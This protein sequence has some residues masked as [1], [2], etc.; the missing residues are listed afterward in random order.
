M[1]AKDELFHG[2]YTKYVQLMRIIA[3]KREIPEADIEDLVQETFVAYYSH[4]PLDWSE[5]QIKAALVKIMRNRCIDY[6]RKQEKWMLTYCDPASI[7]EKML[8]DE[9]QIGR[10]SLSMFL[11]RQELKEVLN[12]LRYMKEDWAEVFLLYIIE[13]RSMEEVS[14]IMGLSADACRARLSRGRKYLRRYLC[15]EEPEKYRPSVRRKTS[16]EGA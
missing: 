9:K 7:Q 12:A 8:F 14:E 10:D 5:C 1:N 15:P 4:Y 11:E 16:P 6:F 2:I 3:R 13:G